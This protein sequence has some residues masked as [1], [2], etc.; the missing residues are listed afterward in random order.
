VLKRALDLTVATF[1]LAVALPA[2]GLIALLVKLTSPGPVLFRQERMGR[3]FRPFFICKFRTMVQDA[4][5]RG[6][7][8]T[9]GDDPR[10]TRVGKLLR[11]T[12]LDEL[13]QLFNVLK[14]DMSLIG[15]RPEV[16]KYVEAY[17]AD[18]EVILQVRPGVS[19][20]ASLEYRDEA[21]LLA[22]AA[23]PE[24]EYRL[25]VLPHKIALA[26]EYVRRSSFWFD[27]SII[28]R[29]PWTL[30]SDY[31]PWR[32]CIPPSPASDTVNDDNRDT[33][34]KPAR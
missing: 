30:L 2:M 5:K 8:I 23:D 3:G 19:D 10:I 9:F 16:P 17:R 34:G 24:A 14:G 22:R 29:T 18:Y 4:P 21:A 31:L 27:L 13:P 32:R 28:V 25:R 7:Q 15:P 11:K 1:V 33:A 26:K 6:T 12:K 20:L